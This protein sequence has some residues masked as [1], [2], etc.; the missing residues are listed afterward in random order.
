MFHQLRFLPIV[1]LL[2]GVISA[3]APQAAAHCQVPC[4]IFNDQARFDAMLEDTTTI[5]KS[6]GQIVELAGTHDAN[7]HNQLARWVVTK[8]E[9]AN[10]VQQTIADYFMAQR[11]KSDAANYAELLKTSHAVMVAAMKSKQSADPATAATLE[12]AIKSFYQTYNGKAY[13][14]AHVH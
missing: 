12:A 9:H 10:K 1:L 5:A 4:G 13:Q 3:T 8:E 14:A 2:L 6:I 11:I 7:G